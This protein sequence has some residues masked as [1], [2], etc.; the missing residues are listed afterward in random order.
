LAEAERQRQLSY[1]DA[2][3]YHDAI[4]RMYADS[5][6]Y[7]VVDPANRLLSEAEAER[8]FREARTPGDRFAILMT[9]LMP[10]L[11]QRASEELIVQSSARRWRW[12]RPSCVTCAVAARPARRRFTSGHDRF[13]RPRIRRQQRQS[14]AGGNLS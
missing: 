2:Q 7:Q 4:A 5:T 9:R 3:G 11:R 8:L 14:A 12:T 6:A 10:A 13:P 1:C